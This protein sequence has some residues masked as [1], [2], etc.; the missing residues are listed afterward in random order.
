MSKLAIII[1]LCSMFLCTQHAKAMIS[2]AVSGGG[3]S[4][5]IG[6]ADLQAGAGSNLISTYQSQPN[7]LGITISGT[8]GIADT[9]RVD[10]RRTDSVWNGLFI[11]SVR[12]TGDGVGG[13]SV[14]GGDVFM[15]I[16]NTDAA[17]FSGAG[18][19]SNIAAQLQLQG[20]SLQVPPNT[21]STTITYTVVDL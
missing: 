15:A 7:L 4:P 11:L 19:L 16:A 12:R 5:S 10:V 20:V 1:S 2:I 13:G 3:W 18:D 8:T 21:Y 9:W 17:F 14:T 6:S